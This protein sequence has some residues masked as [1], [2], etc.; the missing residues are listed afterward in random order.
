MVCG[1]KISKLI[2]LAIAH[3]RPHAIEFIS[4]FYFL[5]DFSFSLSLLSCHDDHEDEDD[6][7]G[8]ALI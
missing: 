5:F 1:W 3:K 4:R 2:L 8:V 6:D 7:A